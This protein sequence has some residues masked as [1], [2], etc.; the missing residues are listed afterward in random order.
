M[1]RILFT[2][3]LLTCG[4][5][6]ALAQDGLEI[7]QLFSGSLDSDRD[8]V[9]VYLSGDA[10]KGYNLTLF[11][12]LDYHCNEQNVYQIERMVL[13]DSRKA[14][15]REIT[16]RNGHVTDAYLQF[17]LS[18]EGHK[19]YLFYR[20]RQAGSGKPYKLNVVY[21]EGKATLDQLKKR[22]GKGRSK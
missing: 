6:R 8:A 18:K 3:L 17:N 15:S 14:G 12:S 4:M 21:M 10:L 22:F 16:R 20:V 5:V 2:L 11:R 9:I 7:G 1:K 13:S 19:G